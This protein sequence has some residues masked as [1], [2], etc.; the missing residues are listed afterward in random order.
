MVAEA[1]GS[2]VGVALTVG[3]GVV[4]AATA[5]EGKANGVGVADRVAPGVA[6]AVPPTSVTADGPEDRR[7]TTPTSSAMAKTAAPTAV[8]RAFKR[9]VLPRDGGSPPSRRDVRQPQRAGTTRDAHVTK[10]T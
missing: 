10:Q 6:D 7:T 8:K 2:A 9:S 5:T 4:V 3:C 1:V